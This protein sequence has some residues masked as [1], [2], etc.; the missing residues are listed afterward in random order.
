MSLKYN[1]IEKE[2]FN[3]DLQKIVSF[4]KKIQIESKKI[5][6]WIKEKWEHRFFL[7]NI[8][9]E[10]WIENTEETRFIIY[11]RL[12]ELKED[13][14]ILYLEKKWFTKKEINLF[15]D[16]AYIL[17]RDFH[18]DKQKKILDYIE[19]NLLLTDFFREVFKWVYLVW[20]SF[21]KFFLSWRSHIINNINIWLE[22]R[23]SQDNKKIIDFLSKNNLFDKWHNWEIS[24]RS[25]SA[26]IYKDWIYSK[27][28]Y[29]TVFKEEVLEITDSISKFIKNLDKFEE[30]IY[31]SKKYYINYLKI[32]KEAF[33]E[34]NTDNL[35]KKWSLVDEAW[36]EIKTP[37][38]ICHPFEFYED[39]YRRAVAPEWDLRILN[40]VFVSNVFKNISEMYEFF[41]DKIWRE[42]FMSSYNY[43]R[44]NIDRVQLYI[45]DITMYFWAQISWLF[46][47]QVV[48]NDEIV[49][50][51]LWKK[52]FALPEMVLENKRQLPFME[53]QSKIFEK[54]TLDNYRKYLF[55]DDEIFYK[56]YD[57]E[58]IWHEY[59][60][61][62]WLDIDSEITMNKDWVF[63]NIEEFKA[64]TW[65][66]VAYFLNDRWENYIITKSLIL[67]HIYRVIWL[68]NYKKINEIEPYY[69]ESL[70][71]LKLLFS[72]W[73]IF[74]NSD[75]KIEVDF[76]KYEKLKEIYFEVYSDLIKNYL[77][78]RNSS[79]FLNKYTIKEKWFYLPLDNDLRKFVNYYYSNYEEIWNNVDSKINKDYYLQK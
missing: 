60:H 32:L 18:T 27:W 11:M 25:Y 49:S 24:D 22:D 54:N 71:H 14:L 20:N 10:L 66:L 21:N 4:S 53:L 8:L 44:S 17:S 56:V 35:V 77:E 67:D 12:V 65:W 68:L 52:I 58:T 29:F 43:S 64:T 7:E 41:Y 16:K 70:I 40:E 55:W 34:K 69:C 42:K 57:I 15:L 50:K 6:S 72:S 76:S 47:A 61:T 45:S 5:F 3:K 79:D 75:F 37:I 46:S 31:F 26:L 9:E 33:L 78:K 13:S 2:K 30:N 19:K 74:L 23:F 39:K 51:K 38:Q 73:I 62:L 59:W 48:P 63:K 28:S 1:S 36:M